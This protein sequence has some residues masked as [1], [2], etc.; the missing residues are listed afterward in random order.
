VRC[1]PWLVADVR[2]RHGH[3]RPNELDER[4]RQLT[5]S[6]RLTLAS[7][8]AAFFAAQCSPP[9]PELS[10]MQVPWRERPH[11]LATWPVR[12][13]ATEVVAHATQSLPLPERAAVGDQ[14]RDRVDH[15]WRRVV[16]SGRR[17]SIVRLAT[18]AL[19][20]L[21]VAFVPL[22]PRVAR[23]AA[24]TARAASRSRQLSTAV[25][26]VL[27]DDRRRRYCRSIFDGRTRDLLHIAR[28]GAC[29]NRRSQA[30]IRSP[31]LNSFLVVCSCDVTSAK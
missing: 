26:E 16:N 14:N 21:R 25:V 11:D 4:R 13:A 27:D 7:N 2:P 6:L 9:S 1:S 15:V 23:L 24:L 8:R 5:F 28:C 17:P 19:K 3:A 12:P 29:S 31:I 18:R 30:T 20:A 10:P 22:R